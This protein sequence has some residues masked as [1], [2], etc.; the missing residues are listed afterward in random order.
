MTGPL[1]LIASAL[2][3]VL[4]ILGLLHLYWM[5]RGVGAGAAV[6]SHPDGRPL[7]RPGRVASLA[8]ALAL[9][10]AATIIL[11]QGGLLRLPLPAE[12]I[13]L[14]TWGVAVAF[15][16]RAIGEFRYVGLF[17]RIT[18]TPFARWDTSLFTP[19][20]IAI[21]VAAFM[22]ARLST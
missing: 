10:A 14:G 6:P 7:F 18:G 20:C 1:T 9:G 2:A 13:R 3:G 22:V 19:L 11:A 15:A 12:L 5:V 17:K 16:A 21:A 4:T 8:V